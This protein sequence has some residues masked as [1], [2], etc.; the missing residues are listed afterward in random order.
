MTIRKAR[1]ADVAVLMPLVRSLHDHEGLPT[2]AETEAS[3][4]RVVESP[5]LGFVLVAESGQV[6]GYIVIGFGFSLEFG[7]RDAFVD[8]LF[9]EESSR[10][11]GF[12]EAMLASAQRE[13]IDAGIRA[14]HLEVEHANA[15]ARLLY[16][17]LGYSSHQRHLLTKWIGP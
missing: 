10:R 1:A 16:E 8:E 13:C 5:E 14:L 12:G 4:R 3:L 9:V 7:G 15:E 11:Q 2:T 17:R 6:V